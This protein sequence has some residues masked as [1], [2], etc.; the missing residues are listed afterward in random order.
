MDALAFHFAAAL[1]LAASVLVVTRRNPVYSAIFLVLFFTMVSL[2]YLTLRAPFLAV[3]QVLVYGG[4]IVVLFLFVLM[5]LN[6]SPQE[7]EEKVSSRRKA[8]A[9]VGAVLLFLLLVATIRLS[10]TVEDA[11]SLTAPIP[12]SSPAAGAGETHAIGVALFNEQ[13]LAFELTS[14]L[15]LVAVIGAI[16][17]TKSRQRGSQADAEAVREAVPTAASG[18]REGHHAVTVRDSESALEEEPT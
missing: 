10:P 14:V 17:L 8:V 7:L 11:G 16:Y 1:A 18:A 13:G 2:C 15:I 3:I 6:L 4:A 5:L 12:A 9:T